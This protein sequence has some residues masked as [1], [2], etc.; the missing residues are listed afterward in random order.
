MVCDLHLFKIVNRAISDFKT[1]PSSRPEMDDEHSGKLQWKQK[2]YEARLR[3]SDLGGM[4]ME[5]NH[6]TPHKWLPEYSWRRV[7]TPDKHFHDAHCASRVERSLH[8]RGAQTI[9]VV[10]DEEYVTDLVKVILELAGYEVLTAANGVEALQIY[11][12]EQERISLVVLDLIMP[13]M[14]GMQCLEQLVITYPGVKVLMASGSPV[15]V[16]TEQ[17]IKRNAKGFLSKPFSMGKILQF[18]R[19]ILDAEAGLSS[20]RPAAVAEQRGAPRKG[21][22]RGSREF[23][24]GA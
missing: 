22:D 21:Q 8:P 23:E 9:L 6:H 2:L 19:D 13:E 24:L 20:E 12:Q 18:V 17:A 7:V 15:D 5:G 3:V 16:R 14:G 1:L 4:Q 10:D 11:R